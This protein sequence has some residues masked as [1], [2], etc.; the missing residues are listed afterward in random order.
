MILIESVGRERTGELVN[1]GSLCS[2]SERS[3]LEGGYV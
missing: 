1:E 3:E 2:G